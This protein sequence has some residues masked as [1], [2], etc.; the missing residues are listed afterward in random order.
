MSIHMVAISTDVGSRYRQLFGVAVLAAGVDSTAKLLVHASSWLRRLPHIVPVQNRGYLLEIGSGAAPALVSM[1]F[2]A[3][4]IV[5]AV[6]AMAAGRVSSL[7]AGLL[8][9]GAASNAIE[10]VARG[11]VTDY[12]AT[13]WIVIDLGD[14]AVLTGLVLIVGARLRRALDISMPTFGRRRRPTRRDPLDL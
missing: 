13:P 6:R 1:S 4:M 8:I 5:W 14:V 3:V 2:L 9:G 11:S 12:L 10:R 7:A